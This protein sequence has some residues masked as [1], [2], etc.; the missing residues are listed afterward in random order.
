MRWIVSVFSKAF[1]T[2]DRFLFHKN[3]AIRA[4]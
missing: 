3:D 2:P 1:F 4:S